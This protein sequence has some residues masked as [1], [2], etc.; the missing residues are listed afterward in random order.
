MGLPIPAKPEIPTS[1]SPEA[2]MEYQQ[3]QFEYNFALQT[4]QQAQNEEQ[5]TKSNMAK[6]RH[7]AMMNVANNL[8]A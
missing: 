5:T 1:T 7:D 8:K 6:S 2:M 3:A 4:A